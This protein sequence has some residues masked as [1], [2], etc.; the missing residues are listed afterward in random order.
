ME[1]SSLG[2]IARE[3]L[4]PCTS[5]LWGESLS[6]VA[7]RVRSGSHHVQRKGQHVKLRVLSGDHTAE[8]W[9]LQSRVPSEPQ[10][11]PQNGSRHMRHALSTVPVAR[12]VE[13]TGSL[14]T[15][16]L[17]DEIEDLRNL[18]RSLQSALTFEEKSSIVDSNRRVRALFGGYGRSGIYV[19]PVVDL[20]MQVLSVKDLFLLKCMVASGQD[21]V[22]DIPSDSLAAFFDSHKVDQSQDLQD[23]SS[24]NP[25]KDAFSMLA[26][27][28]KGW[29]KSS[30][31]PTHIAPGQ[32]MP[33]MTEPKHSVETV[34]VKT[35]AGESN[36]VVARYTEAL[37]YLVR[38][39]ERME[40]FYD[41][42]GGIIGYRPF[43]H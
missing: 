43:P 42:I 24:G 19:N 22:L 41:S 13:E 10:I 5:V 18:M 16:R 14:D 23:Q 3:P 39:L 17:D 7:S 1:V 9:G 38:M 27:L 25:V 15:W 6:G 36:A 32:W 35:V 2:V 33:L 8:S 4:A 37:T 34:H 11:A 29:D 40:K 26:N 28:I 20:A 21:H 31:V 30:E 12:P